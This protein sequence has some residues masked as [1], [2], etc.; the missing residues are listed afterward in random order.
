MIKFAI[1]FAR[2]SGR[3]GLVTAFLVLAA[4]LLEG[5]GLVL[6]VP[7]FAIVVRQDAG[8]GGAAAISRALAA[9]G[10]ASAISQ[11]MILFAVLAVLVVLRALVMY[12]RDISLASLQSAFVEAQKMRTMRAL[13]EA[14]WVRIVRLS[15]ARIVNA[16]GIDSHQITAA[17]A[18][19][20]Q[21]SVAV[22]ML[23]FQ[24]AVALY[25]APIF[26]AIT[27]GLMMIG[28]AFLAV[29]MRRDRAAGGQ[30]GQANLDMMSSATGFLN[31]LKEAIAQ[32]MQVQFVSEF[33]S[34]LQRVRFHH[35]DFVRRTALNRLVFAIASSL[36]AIAM[37]AIGFGLL[38]VSPE[39][40]IAQIFIFMRMTAP[41]AQL[42]QTFRQLSFGLPAFDN[43]ERLEID[44]GGDRVRH[45][46]STTPLPAG[47]VVLREA[48]YRYPTGG[49]VSDVDFTIA[50]GTMLGIIGPS[51][52][53]KTTLVDLLAGLLMP[54]TGSITV[55]GRLLD[56]TSI[57][58]W[59]QDVAYVA[60]DS[61]IFP[62]SIARNLQWNGSAEDETSLHGNALRQAEL[63]E[64]ELREAMSITGLDSLVEKLPQG[65][66]TPVG[67]RGAML[68]GGERQRVAICR[69][70][71]RRPRL[72]ILDEATHALDIASE[73]RVL[74]G[75]SNMAR[76]PTII[77]VAHRKESLARCDQIITVEAGVACV[78]TAMASRARL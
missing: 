21:A 43:I 67:H 26:A 73:A 56:E 40:L 37:A 5:V 70:L 9:V 20:V 49:G 27:I 64:V 13:A 7:F 18:H 3:R 30:Y 72:L 58:D 76:Q 51:G 19:L 77:L 69:A 11:L 55:G 57:D 25:F 2:F 23:V 6:I 63:R 54:Q 4:A 35:L 78:Q 50:P 32:N 47:P 36:V 29:T 53:G 12:A 8:S 1:E 17:A 24:A 44:L 66:E 59:R 28:A 61:F 39:V 34:I 48:G 14:S 31:G 33:E 22:V 10:G 52:S 41:A 75:L 45:Q 60:Q 71:L 42:S 38:A 68:S 16:L 65:L 62:D 74:E 46:R 15:H